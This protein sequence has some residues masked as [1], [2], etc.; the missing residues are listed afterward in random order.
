MHNPAFERHPPGEGF[1][2]GDNGSLAQGRPKLGDQCR[3]RHKAVDL[4]LP[5]RDICGIGAAKPRGRFGYRVQHRF[6]IGG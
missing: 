1:A 5:Y 6:H 3:G 4:T 2:T